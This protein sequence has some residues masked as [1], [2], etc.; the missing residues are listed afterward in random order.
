MTRL[1]GIDTAAGTCSVALWTDG[2]ILAR[3]EEIE[4][5]HAERL[6][7]M[8]VALLAD[9][10]VGFADL[11]AVAV[12]VGPGAFTG[13]RIGLAAARGIALAAGL[14]CFGTT[15]LEAIA[16]D[17]GERR[18]AG[19]VPAGL[20]L[21]VGLDTKR[22]DL[23]GQAFDAAGVPLGPPQVGGADMIAALLCADGE[24]LVAG[25]GAAALVAADA[26]GGGRAIV[27]SECRYPTAAAVARLAARRWMQGERPL[28]PPSPLYLRAADTGPPLT[29]P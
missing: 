29:A 16:D 9:A 14:P 6:M 17:V 24:R 15:T 1:L 26:T 25:D 7:P 18:R 19:A 27:L 21:L 5:G 3:S 23:Y 13:L 11:D 22:R 12:S 20:P 2:A 4:R 8:L 10:G 28:R